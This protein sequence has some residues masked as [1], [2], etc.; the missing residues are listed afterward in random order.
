MKRRFYQANSDSP[1]SWSP[2][3]SLA[4]GFRF[5]TLIDA[6]IRSMGEVMLMG[7]RRFLAI[8]VSM[9]ITAGFEP[10]PKTGHPSAPLCKFRMLRLPSQR[11]Q[12]PNPR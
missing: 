11:K 6:I 1:F 2:V 7:R 12:L 3:R 10:S 9:M 4:V 8:L 5:Q